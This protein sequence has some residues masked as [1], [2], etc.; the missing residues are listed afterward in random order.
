MPGATVL[1][2]PGLRDEAPDHWQTL[3]AARIAQA[4]T[5]KPMGRVDVDL[6]KRLDA[7]ETAASAI[8]GPLVIVAHSAGCI[9][10]AH[11]ARETKRPVLGALLAAPP[12]IGTPMPAG[13][14]TVESLQ[15]AGWFPVPREPLPVA[16]I[17]A[18]SR[19]DPLARFDYVSDLAAVWGARLVD[20]GR[21]GHLNPAS[22]YGD[23][24]KAE[25]FVAELAATSIHRAHCA[26]A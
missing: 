6:R 11:W 15:A 26:S 23:W 21:V 9:M 1:I 18:A 25:E 7:I 22:G 10:L 2:V 13:Y 12:D 24:P 5:V 17:V 16:S 20:L 8:E 4:V 19:N 14:P 3:L